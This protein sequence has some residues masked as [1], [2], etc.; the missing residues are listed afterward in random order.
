MPQEYLFISR[1]FFSH[2]L[3]ASS[4]R[5]VLNLFSWKAA[6]EARLGWSEAVGLS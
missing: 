4:Y 1:F 3:Y 6:Q 2:Q 5:Q